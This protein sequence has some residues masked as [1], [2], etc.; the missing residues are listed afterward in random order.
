M[1]A[2]SLSLPQRDP[3]TFLWPLHTEKRQVPQTS[4]SDGT[5]ALKQY[6]CLGHRMP[7]GVCETQTQEVSGFSTRISPS[8]LSGTLVISHG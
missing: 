5:L 1:G 2:T 3:Q 7:V 8:G 4:K 6:W